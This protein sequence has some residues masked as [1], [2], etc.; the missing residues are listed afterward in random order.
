MKFFAKLLVTSFIFILLS[1]GSTPKVEE[2]KV[3]EPEVTTEYEQPT[4][5]VMVVDEVIV[6]ESDEEYLRSINNIETEEVVSKSEFEFDKAAI[7]QK[8]EELSEIMENEDYKSWMNYITKDSIAYYSSA[9]NIRKA[10]K[11]L[12]DRTIQL[13][14]I[15]DY[16]KY[17]FIPARKNRKVDEIRYISKN[18]VKA[19]QV[20]KDKSIVVYYYFVRENNEW[21]VHIPEL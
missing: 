18:Y 3:K 12:P 8:I 19:V 17:V 16:F 11:M 9:K 14:G 13:Y 10:Q 15:K 4:E 7:L 5:E 6:E 1:C 20:K 2:Q 21:L